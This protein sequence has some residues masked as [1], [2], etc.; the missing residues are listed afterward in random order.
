MNNYVGKKILLID[1]DVLNMK[2]AVKKIEPYG[3]SITQGF[4]AAEMFE[5][6]KNNEYDLILL[7]NMMPV[8]EGIE[9]VQILRGR[10]SKPELFNG[11]YIKPVVVLTGD[12]KPAEEF[13]AAGFDEY[14]GKPLDSTML[15]EVLKKFLG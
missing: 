1:D 9:A 12:S 5:L 2:L 7:D 14:L 11:V 6:L 8:M 15:E 3:C 4:S 10:I 13:L